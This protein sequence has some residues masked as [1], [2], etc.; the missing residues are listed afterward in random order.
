M[1]FVKGKRLTRAA[2]AGITA[3]NKLPILFLWDAAPIHLAFLWL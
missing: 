2:H 1:H 3:L